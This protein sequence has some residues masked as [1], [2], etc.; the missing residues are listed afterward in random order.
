MHETPTYV[1]LKGV[2]MRRVLTNIQPREIDRRGPNV[3]EST[4]TV[5]GLHDCL[6]DV[7]V[8][9]DIDHTWDSDLSVS[10]TGP[11][12]MRVLLVANEGSDGNDFRFTKFDDAAPVS[13]VDRLAPFRGTF[14]P[15][16]SLSDFDHSD[17]NGVWTLRVEDQASQDGGVLN[18][19]TLDIDDGLYSF[20]NSALIAIDAGGPNTATSAIDVTNLTGLAAANV[21]VQVDLRHTWTSDLEL[22]LIAPDDTRVV[23]VSRQGGD[24]DNFRDTLFD[25]AAEISIKDGSAPFAGSF[26]PD[27]PLDVLENLQ[28]NGRWRLE[29]SD[30]ASQDGGSL[31]SW[32]LE[33]QTECA[34]PRTASD[35]NIEVQFMGGLT[36]AQR[37]AFELA[38]ARW[39]EIIT[40]D[41]PSFR[42]LGRDIDDVL[43]LAEGKPIDGPGRILG[44]AGPTHLRPGS[45]LPVRGV[46]TFDSADLAGMEADGS[47]VDVI[48][49]EMGHVLGIGTLWERQK[50]L[51]GKGTDN[52]TFGGTAAMREYG[53]LIGGVP[54][55]VPV[56]NE[57]GPGTRDGHWREFTFDNELM[58][59]IV[60]VDNRLSRLTIACLEDMGYQVNYDAA[61]DYQIPT[62]P[63][64]LGLRAAGGRHDCCVP[65]PKPIVLNPG[66]SAS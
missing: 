16:E 23:L 11:N 1:S 38:A 42:V 21:R 10:L 58:T 50:H 29:V 36:V 20:E 34:H 3:V 8:T 54:S 40:G 9:I 44:R 14:R 2:T 62:A 17:P 22:T 43:I 15:E 60:D 37:A 7:N 25:D 41:L 24:G 4:I 26:R 59:G 61:N 6:R 55:P 19:W 46:M 13:I 52:P 56:E 49:H 32:R 64:V 57:G 31:R 27:Q 33:I 51:A 39:S 12:G 45:L 18:S 48:V 65:R 53:T 35:F 47:L 30:R 66:D 63:F 28:V 5:Q